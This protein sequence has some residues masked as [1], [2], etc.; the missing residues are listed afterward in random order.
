MRSVRNILIGVFALVFLAA[1]GGGGGGGDG[2]LV[3]GSSYDG[4]TAK[5]ALT[6]DNTENMADSTSLVTGFTYGL[7][8]MLRSSSAGSKVSYYS[9]AADSVNAFLAGHT[10][11]GRSAID[12]YTGYGSC[13]G[14]FTGSGSIDNSTLYVTLTVEFTNY[15]E[16]GATFDGTIGFRGYYDN[17]DTIS[18]GT[19]TFG[20][21]DFSDS[22]YHE[23]ISGTIAING[24]TVTLNV[25][26]TGYDDIQYKAENL[27]VTYSSSGYSYSGRVYHGV[28][29]YVDISTPDP[30]RFNSYGDIYTGTLVLTGEN[31]GIKIEY[32]NGTVTLDSDGNGTYDTILG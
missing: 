16:G 9:I 4:N 5:A 2:G 18:H 19:L 28:Y 22:T 31:S 25:V 32:P 30:L 15:C 14:H 11:D 1:C 8:G 23:S 13:G 7:D 29:G 3:S 10:N 17:N 12:T 24:D 20:D 27:A 26:Y 21:C 6:S